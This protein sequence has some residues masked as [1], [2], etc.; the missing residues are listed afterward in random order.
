MDIQEQNVKYVMRMFMPA[1]AAILAIC[2]QVVAGMGAALGT[3]VGAY[4]MQDLKGQIVA[5]Q[6]QA[7]AESLFRVVQ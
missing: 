7:R 2:F 6:L 4:V 1:N 5:S 3:V